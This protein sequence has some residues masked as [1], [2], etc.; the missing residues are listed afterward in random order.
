[1][2]KTSKVDLSNSHLTTLDFGRLQPIYCKEMLPNDSF[3]VDVRAD[4]DVAPLVGRLYGNA[5]LDLHCFFVPNRLVW[6]NFESYI[7]GNVPSDASLVPPYVQLGELF[8]CGCDGTFSPNTSEW[9][10]ISYFKDNVRYLTGL[11]YPLP[12]GDGRTITTPSSDLRVSLLPLRAYRKIWWDYYRNSVLIPEYEKSLYIYDDDLSY[13]NGDDDE[14]LLV[15]CLCRYRSFK[16]DYITTA[17]PS[18][19]ASETQPFADVVAYIN[20]S[21][22]SSRPVHGVVAGNDGSIDLVNAQSTSTVLTDS[23]LS[24]GMNALRRLSG[25]QRYF[26]RLNVVGT[27]PLARLMALFGVQ[28]KAE[29]LDMAEFIGSKSIPLHFGATPI[30]QVSNNIGEGIQRGSHNA[31]GVVSQ[32]SSLSGAV[33]T[34]GSKIGNGSG[35]GQSDT[36]SYHATEHGYFIILASI[37][38]DMYQ[39]QSC[40]RMLLRGLDTENSDRFDWY[41]PDLEGTGYQSLLLGEVSMPHANLNA[42]EMLRWRNFDPLSHVG[43]QYKYEEYRHSQD[44][45]S[46]DFLDAISSRTLSNL[47]FGRNFVLE[48]NS[49]N[50]VR[51]DDENLAT[52]SF[53]N[54][55]DLD[56]KFN[57]MDSKYDHFI[58]NFSIV[59]DAVRPITASEIPT[60]LSNFV[61]SFSQDVANQGVRL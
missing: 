5:H 17:M 40:D 4:I 6:K 56:S 19:V 55:D 21:A 46:G 32:T 14:R 53:K 54:R 31:F 61:N 2:P 23:G 49:P 7:L 44:H 50:D 12:L 1:M 42:A 8:Y 58:G 13:E 48:F 28:P 41:T 9:D 29:R 3:N 10:F 60:E 27:R 37:M 18:T 57:I 26:E 43:Y 30:T 11:G 24:V 59:N 25:L 45:I 22:T 16:K 20:S 52:M 38:P 51:A 33:H 36:F 39:Y 34:Q 35:F 15:E 47:V